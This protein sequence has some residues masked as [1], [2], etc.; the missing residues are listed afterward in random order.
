MS[1]LSIYYV[2]NGQTSV[3][4]VDALN[5]RQ[6]IGPNRP[7]IK[8]VYHAALLTVPKYSKVWY[9]KNRRVI[10]RMKYN[11]NK[12]GVVP[13]CTGFGSFLRILFVSKAFRKH[14][15]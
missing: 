14:Q 8:G 2:K 15:I 5:D 10:F 7:H 9:L 4:K 1:K 11:L 13:Q 12:K 3:H 6:N